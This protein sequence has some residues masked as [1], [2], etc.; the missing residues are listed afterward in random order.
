MIWRVR[1]AKRLRAGTVWVNTWNVFDA[2]LPFGD[3]EESGW[4][5]S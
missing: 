5:G 3:Y 4:P 1:T 2:A